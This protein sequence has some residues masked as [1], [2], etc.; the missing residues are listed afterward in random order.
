MNSIA[1][2][3]FLQSTDLMRR[4]VRGAG[5]ESDG[6]APVAPAAPER[7]RT[8]ATRLRLARRRPAAAQST[9]D[10]RSIVATRRKPARA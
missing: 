1:P 6:A 3:A 10:Q 7:P 5:P 2:I 9:T 8:W 4:A